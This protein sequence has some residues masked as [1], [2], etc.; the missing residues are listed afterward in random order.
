MLLKQEGW[1]FTS[2]VSHTAYLPVDYSSFEL[3]DS[4]AVRPMSAVSGGVDLSV[5]LIT[6]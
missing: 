2:Q 1:N 6:T 4:K 5:H 3:H